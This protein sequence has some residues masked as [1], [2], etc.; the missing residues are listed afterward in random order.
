MS[1]IAL[2]RRQAL[3]A[4]PVL[5]SAPS[6]AQAQPRAIKLG[7]I[8]PVTGALAQDGEYGRIGAELAIA[9][10]NAGGGI[11]ALGGVP[12][13]MVFG[14]ARST[15]D[16]GVAEVEKMQAEGGAPAGK[17]P[18]LCRIEEAK[19][20]GMVK[21]GDTVSIEVKHVETLQ[22]FHFLTGTVRRDGK[23]VLTIR[24]ALALVDQPA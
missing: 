2:S 18:V 16:G 9:D 14:D 19:F 17:T 22:Q 21:P 5:L 15:P 24:F 3:L 11:K 13:E 1:Q 12:I 8:Q 23:A 4:A 6:I 7:I 20:K 10:I